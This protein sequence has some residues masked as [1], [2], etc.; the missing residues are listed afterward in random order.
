MG[1]GLEKLTGK[2]GTK[3]KRKNNTQEFFLKAHWLNIKQTGADTD[4]LHAHGALRQ[5]RPLSRP[6]AA[7][8]V[9]VLLLLMAVFPQQQVERR[10]GDAVIDYKL[11]G[12]GENKKARQVWK[13]RGSF[14]HLH[15]Q[16]LN[17]WREVERPRARAQVAVGPC[18]RYV[19]S[20]GTPLRDWLCS[21]CLLD[22]ISASSSALVLKV[23]SS[24][25]VEER[26]QL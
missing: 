25:N 1:G 3:F 21:T 18:E 26:K 19:P 17:T 4:L 5:Q 12:V 23:M 16:L 9:S 20:C 10:H 7:L 2:K 6:P 22:A 15:P 13:H 8:P 24:C 11:E 14:N